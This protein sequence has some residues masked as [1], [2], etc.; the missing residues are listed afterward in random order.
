P[1]WSFGKVIYGQT[2]SLMVVLP[3]VGVEEAVRLGQRA[4]VEVTRALA[5]P[6]VKLSFEQ[7]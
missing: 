5:C 2:D 1:D 6:P 3:G 7:V 4:A